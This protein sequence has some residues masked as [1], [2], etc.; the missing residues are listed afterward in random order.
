MNNQ[1]LNKDE[2]SFIQRIYLFDQFQNS[3]VI[4]FLTLLLIS[5]ELILIITGFLLDKPYSFVLCIGLLVFQV[6]WFYLV[7]FRTSEQKNSTPARRILETFAIAF[8]IEAFVFFAEWMVWYGSISIISIIYDYFESSYL[9]WMMIFLSIIVSSFFFQAFLEEST[10]Y[11]LLFRNSKTIGFQTRYSI[12]LYSI[13]ASLAIAL[14]TG[15][16][17]T[18]VLIY[19]EFDFI[20]AVATLFIEGFLTTTMHVI[21]GTWIGVGYMKKIFQSTSSE[22]EII[23]ILLPAIFLHGCYISLISSL[24][25]LYPLSQIT[26]RLYCFVVICAAAFLFVALVITYWKVKKLLSNPHIYHILLDS[27]SID[28]NDI[29]S[30]TIDSN[31]PDTP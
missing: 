1:R 23:G 7:Y 2:M 28:L 3:S 22:Y 14:F 29:H 5:F 8:F 17:S 21:T 10:K 18:V 24:R 12:I 30:V 31:D 15:T 11:L 26:W 27:V 20:Y 6:F 19:W 25:M 9:L 13:S 4:I 16:L